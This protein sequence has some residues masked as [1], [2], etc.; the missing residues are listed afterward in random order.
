[1]WVAD[2]FDKGQTWDL[3]RTSDG[4]DSFKSIIS[5]DK[6]FIPGHLDKRS[7]FNVK[8]FNQWLV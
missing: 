5:W 1:M 8:C 4:N 7:S 2:Y 6:Y 3:D